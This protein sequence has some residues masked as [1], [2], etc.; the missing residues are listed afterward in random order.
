MCGR[1]QYNVVVALADLATRGLLRANDA[2]GVARLARRQELLATL[3]LSAPTP[4][5][6]ALRSVEALPAAAAADADAA[7][8]PSS[9]VPDAEPAAAGP[10][11]VPTPTPSPT[12][13]AASAALMESAA[14]ELHAIATDD[15]DEE[16]EPVERLAEVSQLNRNVDPAAPIN[17]VTPH[18][19]EPIV[20]TR[21]P[22]H[23]APL[24]AAAG[25]G[26]VASAVPA[27][28]PAGVIE[29]DP[30]VNKSLL[31]RLIAGVRGL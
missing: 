2:E 26:V 23:P 17:A 19:P 28:N 25:G 4:P 24:A 22:E 31:L 13:A 30:S 29:R 1:G 14:A 11:D 10:F 6:A 21:E 9:T 18:R 5:P 8:D 16:F 15:D 7:T 12:P 27:P 3:D 20:A